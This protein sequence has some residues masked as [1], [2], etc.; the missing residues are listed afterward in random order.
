M[1]LLSGLKRRLIRW[2]GLGANA[3]ANRSYSQEGEDRVLTRIFAGRSPGFYVDVGAHHPQRFSNTQLFYE[4][5][6]SGI[7]IEPNPDAIGE[8]KSARA[9]DINLQL[10]ISDRPQ[11]LTYYCFDDPALNTF[12]PELMKS[13]L[14]STPYKVVKTTQIPV[15]PLADVLAKHLPEE[16]S[17][18]LLT[19]DVEGFDF[20]VLRSNDWTRFRPTWVLVEAL[21]TDVE[22]ALQG[23]LFAFMTKNGYRLF[24][25]TFNTL[26]FQEIPK[27]KGPLPSSR[28]AGPGS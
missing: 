27:D 13:R 28:V 26:F 1:G 8:F 15:E 22:R 19:I 14:A 5:G 25:K 21:E 12:D 18:D 2:M 23:D 6:W 11:I 16:R 17:I 3:Y 24:A 9:R 4:Q 10:G 7:N 20:A